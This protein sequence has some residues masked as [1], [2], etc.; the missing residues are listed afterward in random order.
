MSRRRCARAGAAAFVVGLSLTGPQVAV[1]TADSGDADTAAVS[2]DTSVARAP[3]ASADRQG[4]QDPAS[5]PVRGAAQAE[6]PGAAAAGQA[7]ARDSSDSERPTPA[8]ASARVA[9]DRHRPAPQ[10][11]SAAS[12]VEIPE[13]IAIAP[14]ADT[15]PTVLPTADASASP[16][17][18][19]APRESVAA[20]VAVASP[21]AAAAAV[22][23]Q[24]AVAGLNSAITGLFDA[25]ANWLSGLPANPI[26]EVLSGALLLLRRNLF[27][28]A[29]TAAPVQTT[30]YRSH[31]EILGTL[32]AADAEGD[33]LTYEVIEAPEF[34][35]V[36][37]DAAGH[38]TYT[39]GPDFAGSLT[40]DTFTVRITDAN[41]GFNL[42]DPFGT[43]AIDVVVDA[44]DPDTPFFDGNNDDLTVFLSDTAA[45]IAVTREGDNLLGD[46][47]LKIPGDTSLRWLDENGRN[48]AVSAAEVASDW[49]KITD[50]GAVRL[51][52]S[53]TSDG[54]AYTVILDSVQASVDENGAYVLSGQLAPDVHDGDGVDCYYDVIGGSYKTEYEAFLA[55][56]SDVDSF[57]QDVT[58]ANLFLDTWSVGDYVG[59]LDAATTVSIARAF[60]MAATASA[61]TGPFTDSQSLPDAV[62]FARDGVNLGS[63]SDPV[64]SLAQ[65]A[66]ACSASATCTGTFYYES[67]ATADLVRVAQA[68]FSYEGRSV[69][70]AFDFG[71]AGYG[72]VYVPD[73]VWDKLDY[74]LYSAGVFVAATAGPAVTLNLG[75]GGAYF[76]LA[77]AQLPQAQYFTSTPYGNIAVTGDLAASVGAKLGLPAG[78]TGK[79]SATLLAT[80]AAVLTY[81][82][83]GVSGFQWGGSDYSLTA[84]VSDFTAIPGVSV[85]FTLEPAVTAAWG[86]FTPDSTPILGRVS[87]L[88]VGLGYTK[89]A[90][91]A[92][93]DLADPISLTLGSQGSLGF[94][95]G[96][97]PSLTDELTYSG[98]IDL[99]YTTDNLLA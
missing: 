31:G 36:V 60:P 6:V 91:S 94:S 93:L 34:G 46:V 97:V 23:P 48:G 87:F 58:G 5:G 37:V 66:P 82:T 98:S 77:A 20:A 7:S 44:P 62:A 74:T 30:P 69:D 86:L 56:V 38:Y 33:P 78:S 15:S 54:A 51:G 16:R 73:G 53:Y 29:P 88:E 39:P 80:A 71:G 85:T 90:L 70:V 81:N 42:L 2:A 14:S 21:Q 41:G 26:S 28:Q 13:V 96:L 84:D 75:A 47:T 95:A 24:Q 10:P 55:A 76:A 68:T 63:A 49:D 99:G 89:S 52:L 64:F 65:F 83:G 18:L 61:G 43:H 40:P 4:R 11:L 8:R 27:D 45:R 50:A 12:D 57:Q 79:L 3:K 25:A 22:D 72:Y 59:E 17:A 67:L 92:T 9:A 32:G 35:T 19:V 1:A